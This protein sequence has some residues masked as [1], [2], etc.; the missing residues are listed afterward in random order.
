MCV[1]SSGLPPDVMHNVLE[2]SVQVE[3]CCMLREFIQVKK[4]FSLQ[5]LNTRIVNFPWGADA[6]DHPPRP[7]ADKFLGDPRAASLKLGGIYF[8]FKHAYAEQVQRLIRY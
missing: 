1:Y 7:L 6:K 2:G 4:V 3:V 8:V 5:T